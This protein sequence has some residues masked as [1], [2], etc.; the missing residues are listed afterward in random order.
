MPFIGI[1]GDVDAQPGTFEPGESPSP[2]AL[3]GTSALT[4]TVSAPSFLSG[5]SLTGTDALTFTVSGTL[6]VG[7]GALSG[8]SHLQFGV[9]GTLH[10]AIV[11]LTGTSALRFGV[12]GVPGVSVPIVTGPTGVNIIVRRPTLT[13]KID[14]V[15][16]HEIASASCHF[17]FDSR[18]ATA[19]IQYKAVTGVTPTYW[20]PVEITMGAGSHNVPR[21]YGYIL[22]IDNTS[23]PK[24]GTLRCRGPLGIAANLPNAANEWNP[25]YNVYGTDFTNIQLSGTFAKTAGSAAIVGTGTA[26]TTELAVGMPLTLPGPE[27][28]DFDTGT[29]V[30]ITDDTHLTIDV[31]VAAGHDASGFSVYRGRMDQEIANF[32]LAYYGLSS[33]YQFTAPFGGFGDTVGGTGTFL[34]V[35]PTVPTWTW[36][37]GTPGLDYLDQLDQV[38]AAQDSN[39]NWGVYK[40]FETVGGASDLTV[41]RTLITANPQGN[42]A[43]ADFR[44]AEGVD[45]M[46]DMQ[47]SHDPSQVVNGIRVVGGNPF[48][49]TTRQARYPYYD[50][51]NPTVPW[52]PDIPATPPPYFTASSFFLPSFLPNNPTTG[53][54]TVL[55]DFSFPMIERS[56]DDD[57]QCPWTGLTAEAKARQLLQELNTEVVSLRV[58]TYRDDVFGP[59]QT[60]YIYAPVRAGVFQTMW[61]NSLDITMSDKRVFRQ[62]MQ[63]VVKN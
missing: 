25:F 26:F 39:G 22:P 51:S 33:R 8:T 13:V 45:L 4:V 40:T 48:Q 3:S 18:F 12:N 20:L 46:K 30:S 15:E 50:P 60:H 43:D 62:R 63:Y 28:N 1:P 59:G 6:T 36:P 47:V 61:L 55:R 44:L 17:G 23:F 49:D 35:L 2:V 32:I 16:Q 14:G 11:D 58:S 21:F 52:I 24:T 31:V 57:T 37:M 53:Y 42:A 7:T 56:I 9:T 34:G 5:V 54:P 10:L 27:M 29:I 19:E 41:F 38:C